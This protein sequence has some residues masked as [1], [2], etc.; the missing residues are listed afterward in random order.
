M[1]EHRTPDYRTTPSSPISLRVFSN[2]DS[3]NV[4]PLLQRMHARR[5]S[6]RWPQGPHR[7][8]MMYPRMVRSPAKPLNMHNSSSL[9]FPQQSGIVAETSGSTSYARSRVWLVI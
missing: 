2:C 1:L 3:V 6:Q 5:R 8:V 4:S 7:T 9:T